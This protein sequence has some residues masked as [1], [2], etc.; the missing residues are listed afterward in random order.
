VNDASSVSLP[1]DTFAEAGKGVTL[2]VDTLFPLVWEAAEAKIGIS[3]NRTVARM[4]ITK[5]FTLHLV[6]ES[7]GF[8]ADVFLCSNA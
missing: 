2:M 7:R 5:K 3:R 6:T 1:G 8:L 4:I